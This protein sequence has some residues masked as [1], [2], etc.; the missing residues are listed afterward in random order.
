MFW[1][2]PLGLAQNERRVGRARGGRRRSERVIRR[3][4][5]AGSIR[6]ASRL[7][8]GSVASVAP[9]SGDRSS[10]KSGRQAS[11]FLSIPRFL[12]SFFV[13]TTR[14]RCL[15]NFEFPAVEGNRRVGCRCRREGE[16]V[17]RE[18]GGG[19]FCWVAALIARAPP[20]TYAS[21][22]PQTRYKVLCRGAAK[23]RVPWGRRHE[24]PGTGGNGR[25]K[26]QG[27]GN[28]L[29]QTSVT[30]RAGTRGWYTVCIFARPSSFLQGPLR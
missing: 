30:E 13:P 16:R 18:R 25:R 26:E 24:E 23:V 28:A 2:S 20:N 19:T 6:L 3:V 15:S 4:Q 27:A 12:P 14:F 5:L 10:G 1:L 8:I 11:S 21:T 29:V 9:A 22:P 17:H 7:D